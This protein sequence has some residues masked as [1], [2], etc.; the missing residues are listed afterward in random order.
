MPILT[1][2]PKVIDSPEIPY[3]RLGVSL[4]ISPIWKQN[5]VEAAVSITAVPYRVL[6]DGSIDKLES[7][8]WSY[9]CGQVF[10]ASENDPA[11]AEAAT[12]LMTAVQNFLAAKGA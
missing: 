6:P 2:T 8:A 7:G 5:D 1:S 3:D 4:A 9:N 11:L 10:A 12:A